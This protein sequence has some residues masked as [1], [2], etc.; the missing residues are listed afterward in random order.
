MSTAPMG[1]SHTCMSKALGWVVPHSLQTDTLPTLPPPCL[2][3]RGYA[4][5]AGGLV[6]GDGAVHGRYLDENNMVGTVP[7]SLS[8]MMQLT[9][10]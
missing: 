10:L 8:A 6:V 1:T 3:S 9:D 2:S 4:S 5:A 7:A